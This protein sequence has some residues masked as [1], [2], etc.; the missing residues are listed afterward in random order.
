M[1]AATFKEQKQPCRVSDQPLRGLRDALLERRVDERKRFVE[2]VRNGLLPVP[3]DLNQMFL[4]ALD[5][6]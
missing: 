4:A 6:R 2:V 5:A 1:K 3:E